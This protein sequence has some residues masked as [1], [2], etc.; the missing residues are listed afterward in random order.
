MLVHTYIYTYIRIEILTMR[1]FQNCAQGRRLEAEGV[2]PGLI[3]D[4]KVPEI[5]VQQWTEQ[6]VRIHYSVLQLRW[7]HAECDGL[8]KKTILQA[9]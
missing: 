3:Q 4:S 7:Y 2:P 5:L 8:K 6:R 9:L 1:R